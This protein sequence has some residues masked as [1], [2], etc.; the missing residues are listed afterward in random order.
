[1]PHHPFSLSPPLTFS[2]S[3]LEKAGRR[4]GRRPGGGATAAVTWRDGGWQR[5]GGGDAGEGEVAVAKATG[6]AGEGEV[7]ATVPR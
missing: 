4:V 2:L 6:A 5:G 7:G 3:S 1:M